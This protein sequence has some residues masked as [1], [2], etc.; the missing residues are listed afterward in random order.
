MAQSAFYQQTLS[1]LSQILAEFSGEEHIQPETRLKED[2][3]LDSLEIVQLVMRLNHEF[4]VTVAAHEITPVHFGSLKQL[5]NFI[6]IKRE[7]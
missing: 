3:G 6:S 7:G 1:Q 2:L 5:A 4:G